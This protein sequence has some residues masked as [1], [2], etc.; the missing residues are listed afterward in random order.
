M[1]AVAASVKLPC[2]TVI[3]TGF[4]TS[5]GTEL[6]GARSAVARVT[7][8]ICAA[9]ESGRLTA[10]APP[11]TVSHVRLCQP[12]TLPAQ[13]KYLVVVMK[14]PPAGPTRYSAAKAD[15]TRD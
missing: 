3:E 5:C 1:L 8:G 12:R 9:T 2:P 11:S 6:A 15:R 7:P 10:R 13:R 14:Q 4:G